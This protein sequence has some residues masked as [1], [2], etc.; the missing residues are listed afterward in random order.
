M[1][2]SAY[3]AA[4]AW[5]CHRR[6]IFG[7]LASAALHASLGTVLILIASNRAQDPRGSRGYTI[8]VVVPPVE[9]PEPSSGD[10]LLVAD[11]QD[12]IAVIDDAGGPERTE[13]LDFDVEKLRARREALFPFL[14]TDLSFLD[15]MNEQ[16]RG[17]R[18]A[19]AIPLGVAPNTSSSLPPL[20]LSDLALQQMIDRAWSRRSRWTAFAEIAG[21]LRTHDADDGQA[22]SVLRAYVDQ[23]LLQL[24]C[25]ASTRAPRVWAMLENAADHT[26]FIDFIGTFTQDRPSSLATTELLF[27]LDK[28]AQ[29]SRDALLLL[30]SVDPALE[31]MSSGG[32][33]GSELAV[34]LQSHYRERLQHRR[35]TSSQ[36]IKAWYTMVR[37]RILST[38]IATSPNGYRAAD[39]RFLAGA[40]HFE[41]GDTPE[42][43]QWWREI[44]PDSRD[45]YVEE[46]SRLLAELQWSEGIRPRQIKYVLDSVNSRWR[47]SSLERLRHFGR[48]C[49]SY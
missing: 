25:D 19:P 2:G 48:T 41:Q 31:L 47:A 26:D 21:L 10:H 20:R 18:S 4:M 45:R 16:V 28:L 43:I 7:L 35:L 39:A 3:K 34:A 29:A 14:T 33:D 5:R 11:S 24:F 6:S 23:N 22:P 36:D 13:G 1:Q 42:A 30:V 44:R 17:A 27:L 15:R 46:Y 37:L 9:V 8:A 40:L 12:P 38:V 49:D 32:G